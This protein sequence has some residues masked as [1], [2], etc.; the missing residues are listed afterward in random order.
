MFTNK[1]R[2][3]IILGSKEKKEK[4]ALGAERKS[5]GTN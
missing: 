5:A 3:S 4:K 1:V 2:C